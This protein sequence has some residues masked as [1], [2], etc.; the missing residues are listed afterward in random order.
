MVEQHDSI[1]H[2]SEASD[3]SQADGNARTTKTLTSQTTADP[4]KRAL[5]ENMLVLEI[6]AGTGKLTAAVRKANLR[7]VAIDRSHNR[8]KGAITILDLTLADDLKFLCDFIREKCIILGS[9]SLC[10]TLRHLFCS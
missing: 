7:G 5:F 6:F 8:S 9:Y 3:N 2:S 4:P 1:T 10:S